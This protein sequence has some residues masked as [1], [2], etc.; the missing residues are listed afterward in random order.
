MYTLYVLY[1]SYSVA[2]F[3]SIYSILVY[4]LLMNFFYF[5]SFTTLKL[6]KEPFLTFYT[7]RGPMNC[8]RTHEWAGYREW[9]AINLKI[10]NNYLKSR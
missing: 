7:S 2:S 8:H 1:L 4:L 5:A 10:D 6:H 3:Y 9:T